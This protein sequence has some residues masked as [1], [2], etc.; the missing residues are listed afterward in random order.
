MKIRRPSEPPPGL[1]REN[2]KIV[3]VRNYTYP[4]RNGSFEPYKRIVFIYVQY[5]T[6]IESS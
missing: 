6:G 2:H 3:R 5:F 4:R 1:K